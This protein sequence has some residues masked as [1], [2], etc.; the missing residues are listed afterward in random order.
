ME[1]LKNDNPESR[2]FDIQAYRNCAEMC[3][4]LKADK[5]GTECGLFKGNL[6]LFSMVRRLVLEYR[7]EAVDVSAIRQS[8]M[9][10]TDSSR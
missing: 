4:F 3:D 8:I 1:A 10:S 7:L 5:E 9:G 6:K 2:C